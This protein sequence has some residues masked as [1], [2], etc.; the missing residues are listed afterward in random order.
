VTHRFHPLYG[1][2][3]EFVVYRQNRGADRFTCAGPPRA[4]ATVIAAAS[5]GRW[6]S[7]SSFTKYCYSSAPS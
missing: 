7:A 3:F 5:D 6:P 4:E 1:R 2:E